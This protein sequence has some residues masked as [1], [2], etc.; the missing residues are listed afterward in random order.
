MNRPLTFALLLALGAALVLRGLNL[1]ERPMHNDE[2]VNAIKFRGLWQRG[3]FKY[4][5]N[6]HHGPSLFYATLAVSR[7]SAAPDF[8]R[9]TEARL[10][11]VTVLF[12]LGLVLL[13]PLLADALGRQATVWAALFIAIS[14]AFVFYSRY[15][16]HETLLVFFA[17]LTF[18]AGWKYWRT[19]RLGWALLAGLGLGFMSATKETFVLTL[20][21]AALA[22]ALNR[23]WSAWI[24]ASGPPLKTPRLNLWHL[25]AAL[26]LALGVAVV[27]FTSFFTNPAGL[28]DSVRTYEPWLRRA[29]GA[30]PH[31]HLW[32][33]YL[34]RLLFFHPAKG[35]VWTEALLLALGLIAA[36][37]AFVRKRIEGASASCVRFL[38]LYT[39]LLAMIYSGVAYKTPWC[40]LSFWHGMVL[41]AGVGAAVLLRNLRRKSVYWAV[42][43]LLA[44]GSGHL[45]WQ[46]WELETT[47]AADQ[48]NP[49]VYAQTSPD[50][51]ELV[52]QLEKL[53]ALSP[54]G[55]RLLIQVAAVDGDYW[56]LPWYLRG[57]PQVGWWDRL[58]ADRDSAVLIVSPALSKGIPE[59]QAH[60]MGIFGLRPQVFLEL[61]VTDDLWQRWMVR[62]RSNHP[63]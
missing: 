35:P 23:V 28:M 58:P 60:Q 15:F 21:A 30:S 24:D 6:E 5:P 26:V 56:P 62:N 25:T 22:G 31:I 1:A 18:V 38:C 37:A 32:Y 47:Y 27:L 50:I 20:A 40:L 11:W 8:E 10:R 44:A 42:T 2:A 33:F 29:E 48:R 14:P 13:L 39:L 43:L 53:A 4:D 52:S 7:L 49:Y 19:R 12:G 59:T 61:F 3:T 17:F 16:I 54:Q 46:A 9:F 51:L 41:L 34:H 45:A 55:N 63:P 36:W 57:F